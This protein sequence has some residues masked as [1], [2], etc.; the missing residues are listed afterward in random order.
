VR[1]KKKKNH[2]LSIIGSRWIE[3]IHKTIALGLALRLMEDMDF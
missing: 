3:T 1:K 2:K